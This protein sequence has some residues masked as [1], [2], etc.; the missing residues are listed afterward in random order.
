MT[1]KIDAK[2]VVRVGTTLSQNYLTV[3]IS[4]KTL[5]QLS[6]F[7]PNAD[8]AVLAKEWFALQM[9]LMVMSISSF[10]KDDPNGIEISKIFRREVVTGYTSAEIYGPEEDAVKYLK[11]RLK[12]YGE[13][14]NGNYIF[15]ISK[16]FLKLINQ[17]DA[18]LLLNTGEQISTFLKN[19]LSLVKQVNE[20]VNTH[21]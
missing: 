4:E 11:N 10:Y 2:M 8:R 16:Y 20:E 12:E 7:Y 3:L 15:E 9:F 14:A 21:P 18:L 19:N 1:G 5:N 17:E 13:I 6:D